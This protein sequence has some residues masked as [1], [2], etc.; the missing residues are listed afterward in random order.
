MDD[1][2]NN[3]GIEGDTMK[4]DNEHDKHMVYDIAE[5]GNVERVTRV[6]DL[7][8]NFCVELCFPYAKKEI[9]K[10]TY[11]DNEYE[12][13]EE[14]VMTLHLPDTFSET[15][16][17]MLETLIHEYMVDSVMEDWMDLTKPESVAFW[18]QKLEAAKSEII[19]A[20]ARRTRCLTRKMNPF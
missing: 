18:H 12:V 14:Y 5:K 4:R 19:G 6:L 16:V 7:A 17:T 15:T 13:E 20:L 9:G 10:H 3:A 8:F 1:I 11:R 2:R